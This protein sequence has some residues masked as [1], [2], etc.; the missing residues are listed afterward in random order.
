MLKLIK[1]DYEALTVFAAVFAVRAHV[2]SVFTKHAL[3]CFIMAKLL[4]IVRF[5]E[6]RPRDLAGV[7]ASDNPVPAGGP[8]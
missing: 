3:S 7:P 6:I 5:R 8:G 2:L 1:S 4:Q